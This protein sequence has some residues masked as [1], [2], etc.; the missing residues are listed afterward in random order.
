MGAGADGIIVVTDG[1]DD[2]TDNMLDLLDTAGLV[3]HLQNP[4]RRGKSLQ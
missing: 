1:C 3:P 4:A 2:G